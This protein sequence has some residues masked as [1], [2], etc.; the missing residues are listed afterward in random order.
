MIIFQNKLLEKDYEY[1]VGGHGP[2]GTRD[3]II[4]QRDFMVEIMDLANKIKTD[5]KD[6]ISI[7]QEELSAKIHDWGP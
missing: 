2:L 1:Y 4:N 7:K 3:D 5:G 6:I